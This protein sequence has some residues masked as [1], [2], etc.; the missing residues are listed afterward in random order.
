MDWGQ[1]WRVV[2]AV[3][4]G[5]WGGGAVVVPVAGEGRMNGKS[6]MEICTLPY[7]K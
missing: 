1:G 2:W 7:V 4:G 6:N 3:G 5:G